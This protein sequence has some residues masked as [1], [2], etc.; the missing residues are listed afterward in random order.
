M[1]LQAAAENRK[2]EQERF[3]VASARSGSTRRAVSASARFERKNSGDS[4][5]ESAAVRPGGTVRGRSLAVRNPSDASPDTKKPRAGARAGSY[6][7][8]SP[9]M[10]TRFAI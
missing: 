2:R 5:P 9:S 6:N 3:E 4:L 7:N 8:T 1:A 10:R